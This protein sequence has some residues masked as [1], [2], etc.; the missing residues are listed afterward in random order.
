MTEP[1][2]DLT[3]DSLVYLINM[4]LKNINED[5]TQALQYADILAATINGPQGS[6][7][8]LSL[9]S[10]LLLKELSVAL[11]GFLKTASDST[12][13][14]L[15]LAKLL[16]DFLIKVQDDEIISDEEREAIAKDAADAIA[17][18]ESQKKDIDSNIREFPTGF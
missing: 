3:E 1:R 17:R 18:A 10:E 12:E 7:G 9:E 8:V 15:K 11:T 2:L 14:A 5:R 6:D 4:I 16:V 13:R